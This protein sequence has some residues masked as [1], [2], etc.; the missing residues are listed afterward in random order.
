MSYGNKDTTAM[1]IS[2]FTVDAE[3]GWENFLISNAI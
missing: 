1:L 3:I 2:V